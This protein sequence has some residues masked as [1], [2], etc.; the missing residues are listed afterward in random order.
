MVTFKDFHLST[1]VVFKAC[2]LPKNKNGEFTI[3]GKK[4]DYISKNRDGEPSSYY[5]YG[6]DSKGKYVIRYSNH[7]AKIKNV[8]CNKN[9]TIAC[10]MVGSCNWRILL[11]RDT[12][13]YW[14]AGKA[15]L[16][17]FKNI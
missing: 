12:T 8:H 3:A 15:Y 14:I 10:T 9:Y 6:E 17:K 16:T 13:S 5:W 11:G 4:P 2:K 7:W 1:S